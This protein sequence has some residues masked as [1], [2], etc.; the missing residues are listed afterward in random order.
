MRRG[1]AALLRWRSAGRS[2]RAACCPR[3]ESLRRGL[4]AALGPLEDLARDDLP[5]DLVGALVALGTL[6]VA[7][8][9]L[10]ARL[11]RI[12]ARAEQLHSLGG[13]THGHVRR[14]PFRERRHLGQR[15]A[16]APWRSSP[17]RG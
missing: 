2:R 1:Y 15:I 7:H 4:S 6:S 17:S 9:P 13:D 3:M 12:A 16:T 5:V 10:D 8:Q 14:G 11:P